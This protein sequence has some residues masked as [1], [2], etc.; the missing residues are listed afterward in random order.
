MTEDA[1]EELTNQVYDGVLSYS[2]CMRVLRRYIRTESL[3]FAKFTNWMTCQ[4]LTDGDHWAY[5]C[6]TK[7]ERLTDEELYEKYLIYINKYGNDL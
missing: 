5:A 1:L 6:E 2:E 3:C 7:Y 4:D